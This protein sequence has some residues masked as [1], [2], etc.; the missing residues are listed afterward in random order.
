MLRRRLTLA[1]AATCTGAAV[2]ASLSVLDQIVIGERTIR[3]AMLPS[4]W[5][6]LVSASAA[7]L[8]FAVVGGLLR[9]GTARRATRL[10]SLVLPLCSLTLLTLPYLP[11]L[12]DRWPALQA[13]A[14]PL[15]PAVWLVVAALQA[16][17]LWQVAAV[18]PAA[19]LNSRRPRVAVAICAWFSRGAIWQ[20]R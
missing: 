11:I 19:L 9:R 3:V 17:V 7:A 2:F 13:L 10:E 16:W 1:I 4:W 20:P 12:P 6:L 15:V 8:M 18:D 14:G 5:V